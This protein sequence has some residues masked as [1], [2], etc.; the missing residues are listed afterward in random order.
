M[1]KKSNPTLCDRLQNHG[2]TSSFGDHGTCLSRVRHK[3]TELRPPHGIQR[4]G[5]EPIHPVRISRQICQALSESRCCR[6]IL[7]SSVLHSRGIVGTLALEMQNLQF[8]DCL[9]TS[10]GGASRQDN[11]ARE[12]AF[13]RGRQIRP[14]DRKAKPGTCVGSKHCG[15]SWAITGTG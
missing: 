4:A 6:G 7:G 5:R 1:A 14:M 3:N 15:Q 8:G 13:D 11:N 10:V 12:R 9:L 2:R